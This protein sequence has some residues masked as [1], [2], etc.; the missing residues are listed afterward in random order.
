MSEKVY[1][2]KFTFDREVKDGDEVVKYE[3][4]KVYEIKGEASRDR[5]L[6]RGCIEV[7]EESTEKLNEEKTVEKKITKKSTK[8]KSKPKEEQQEPKKDQDESDKLE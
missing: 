4:G 8:L 5:W 3:K 1:K 7:S 6:K 2:L